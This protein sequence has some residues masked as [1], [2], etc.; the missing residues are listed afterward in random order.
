[1]MLNKHSR[2][3]CLCVCEGSEVFWSKGLYLSFLE[4]MAQLA[5]KV[6]VPLCTPTSLK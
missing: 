6:A 2:I 4:D 5:S 1:M 3:A